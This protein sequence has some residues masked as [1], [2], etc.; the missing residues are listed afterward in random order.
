MLAKLAIGGPSAPDV[1][2]FARQLAVDPPL[3]LWT[4]CSIHG[5]SDPPPRTLA[6]L[7]EWLAG[8]ALAALRLDAPSSTPEQVAELGD[9]VHV[10]VLAA[11]VYQALGNVADSTL[12]EDCLLALLHNAADWL[13]H[14]TAPLPRWLADWHADPAAGQ[15]TRA[16]QLA[17]L[18]AERIEPAVDLAGCRRRAEQARAAWLA[19]GTWPDELLSTL[20]AKLARL[21]ELEAHFAESLEHEKLQ[22]LAEF[23][24]GA[25]HEI[26]NPLAVIAGRAQLFLREE[27]D[28][29][30]RR[31]LALINAQAM[32]V[33]EMIADLRLFARPPAPERKNVDLSGLAQGVLEELAPR[34]AEQET[35][36]KC[37]GPP[38]ALCVEADPVQLTVALK[39]LVTN[40]I[41]ALGSGGHVEVELGSGEAEVWIRV[42]DDG[43]GI[44]PE[45]RKRIFDPFFSARQAGRGLGMGL[46]KCWRIVTNHGGRMEVESQPG[47]GTAFTIRLPG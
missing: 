15:I 40:A 33:Y 34:A 19:P 36:L 27:K 10:A 6:G 12:S 41:E 18:P 16:I 45:E 37:Q 29:E 30:R 3:A 46:A 47:H 5:C 43:P 13:G 1:D 32:R 21:A 7:A 9:L 38:A 20:A 11:E 24:A 42:V 35:S 2:G 28:P 4:V 22:S 14:S 8:H 26:N 23:A 31:G 44:A 17:E 25:G 39:A